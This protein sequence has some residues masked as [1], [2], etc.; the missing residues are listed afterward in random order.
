MRTRPLEKSC[1]INPNDD[2]KDYRESG[3]ENNQ[4]RENEWK[5]KAKKMKEIIHIEFDMDDDEKVQTR[6]TKDRNTEGK[7]QI[8]RKLY[9][10][11][12]LVAKTRAES[13]LS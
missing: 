5:K 9:T 1:P 3:I 10:I 6:N 11:M 8:K 4:E 2:L 12:N 13:K 7:V